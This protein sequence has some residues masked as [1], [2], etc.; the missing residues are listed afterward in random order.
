MFIKLFLINSYEQYGLF[1]T[2]DINN[3][4]CIYQ[5]IDTQYILYISIL[6]FIEI[7]IIFIIIFLIQSLVVNILYQL[8]ILL[9]N[10]KLLFLHFLYYENYPLYECSN[11]LTLFLFQL[12]SKLHFQFYLSSLIFLQYNDLSVILLKS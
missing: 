12:N 8:V 11:L 7:F 1:T 6:S 10:Y 5:I 9:S 3:R 4:W 2:Y